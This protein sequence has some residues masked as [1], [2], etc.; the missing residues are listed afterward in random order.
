MP[1]TGF[2]VESSGSDS[3]VDVRFRSDD[4]ESRL[5]AFWRDG[6]QAEIEERRR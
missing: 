6:P 2:R 1:A 4:H 5:H 3:Q